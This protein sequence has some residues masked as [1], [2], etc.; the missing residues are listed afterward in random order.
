MNVVYILRQCAK[1]IHNVF[2][3]CLPSVIYVLPK[4]VGLHHHKNYCS[5]CRCRHSH[6]RHLCSRCHHCRSQLFSSGLQ[7]FDKAVIADYFCYIRK[8][9]SNISSLQKTFHPLK[10]HQEDVKVLWRRNNKASVQFEL[11]YSELIVS[12]QVFYFES[13]SETSSSVRGKGGGWWMGG[14]FTS[15]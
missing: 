5:H 10:R 13:P 14:H 4:A 12:D 11:V 6:R 3:I 15:Q 7:G 1:R 8:S 9:L 2:N